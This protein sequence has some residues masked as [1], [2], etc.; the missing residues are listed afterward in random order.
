MRDYPVGDLIMRTL[1][2][3]T[4]LFSTLA[5]AA[6]SYAFEYSFDV[7]I[8]DDVE[9]TADAQLM[10]VEG[11]D[12][13]LE[14]AFPSDQAD[15]EPDTRDYRGSGSTCCSPSETVYLYA[16]IDLDGNEEWDAGEPWGEDPNNPVVIEDDGYVG[17]ILVE[18]DDTP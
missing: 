17:E 15:L 13:G 11:N 4:L 10:M 3:A 5:T 16:F 6:C 18:L 2:L 8:A 7:T 9:L 14:G 1:V 12:D